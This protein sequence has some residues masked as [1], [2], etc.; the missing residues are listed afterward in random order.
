M[1][2]S[3][4]NDINI[5]FYWKTIRTFFHNQDAFGGTT[6]QPHKH[7][8]FYVGPSGGTSTSIDDQG[9]H[10]ELVGVG[11]YPFH[12]P[13]LKIT[14]YNGVGG[15][16]IA[17]YDVTLYKDEHHKYLV[18]YYS[19]STYPG[20]AIWDKENNSIKTLTPHSTSGTT[21]GT[22]FSAITDVVIYD[23]NNDDTRPDWGD[24]ITDVVFFTG[25]FIT[26]DF[27]RSEYFNGGSTIDFNSTLWNGSEP[28]FW[29]R[30]GNGASD[31]TNAPFALFNG[32]TIDDY[33]G[34]NY[35]LTATFG[36][37]TNVMNIFTWPYNTF[38]TEI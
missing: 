24:V 36:N 15:E 20:L 35:D 8:L 21:S 27:D 16:V 3:D 30:F 28:N 9:I 2:S 31:N 19:T 13:M 26:G 33:S 17:Y 12:L 7:R 29:Y 23:P 4:L 11:I 10:V 22:I 6:S 34:N 25:S 38:E 18:Y 5:G 14:G 1:C 32:D 37:P